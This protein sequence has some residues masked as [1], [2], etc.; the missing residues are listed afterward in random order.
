MG[1]RRVALGMGG[2]FLLATVIGGVCRGQLPTTKPAAAEA[3]SL[4]IVVGPDTTVFSGPIMP[5]GTVD[6]VAAI[7]EIE[8]KGITPANNAACLLVQIADGDLKNYPA[9]ERVE[10]ERR[11]KILRLLGLRDQLDNQAVWQNRN[12]FQKPIPWRWGRLPC[13]SV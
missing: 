2:I 3:N 1:G 8:G 11:E 7:N 5:D 9:L 10:L 12:V 6:Y 4:G 13:G